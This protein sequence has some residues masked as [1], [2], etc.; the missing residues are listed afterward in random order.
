MNDREPPMPQ[1]TRQHWHDL[2]VTAASADGP[3]ATVPVES[4]RDL[5]QYAANSSEV[6][7]DA[8]LEGV[9][10][11]ETLSDVRAL[12]RR[13]RVVRHDEQEQP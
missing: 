7:Y 5:L 12:G 3:F 13:L 9:A 2:L 4:L 1:P 11:S 8:G 6:L 10:T